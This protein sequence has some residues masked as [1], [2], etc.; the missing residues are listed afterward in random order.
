MG[1]LKR[2]GNKKN[3]RLGLTALTLGMASMTLHAETVFGFPAQPLNL[4]LAQLARE[5]GVN[6]LAQDAILA[7]Y[8]APALSGS[9]SVGDALAQLLRGT[10][11]HYEQQDAKTFVIKTAPVAPSKTSSGTANM[12]PTI[13]VSDVSESRTQGFLADATSTATRTDTPIGQTAQS[14]QVVTKDLIKSK[15]AQSALDVLTTVSGVTVSNE[16]VGRARVFVRGL[17]APTM[18]NGVNDVGPISSLQ[19]PVAGIER[20]EVLKGADSILSGAMSPG[21]VV[22]VALK[23]PTANT[24]REV[25]VQT[26]SY[27]NFLTSLD[28]GGAIDL[29]KQFLYRLVLSADRSSRTSDGYDG[30]KNVYLA[31]SLTWKSDGRELTAGYQH[32][33]QNV[34][35]AA[36]TIA[37]ANG[38]LT[39]TS[40]PTPSQNSVIQTDT[41]FVNFKQRLGDHIE[42]ENRTQ[43]QTSTLD[44]R[45]LY[46]LLGGTPQRAVYQSINNLST[47][48]GVDTDTHIKAKFATGELSHTLLAGYDYNVYWSEQ[49]GQPL[50]QVA[51]TFPA[52]TLPPNTS[53]ERIYPSDRSYFE[54]FYLQDQIAWGGLHVLASVARGKSWSPDEPSQS[55][56]TPNLG[57]LYQVTD[58]IA[59]YTNL[60]RSYR[61]SSQRLDDGTIAPPTSGQSAEAGFK[62]NLLDERLSI[63]TAVFRNTVDNSVIVDPV[64]GGARLGNA[65]T[66]RGAELN[67]TGNLSPGLNISGGYAYTT[68]VKDEG[69]NPEI[70]PRHSANLW[71]TYDLQSE[72]WR[73]WGAGVGVDA[74]SKYAYAVPQYKVFNPVPGQAQTDLTVYYRASTWSVNLGVKNV[75][76]R[77][78]YQNWA[79]SRVALNPGRLV[80]LTGSFNF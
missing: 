14:I 47:Y 34:P 32:Q 75:F 80:Y 23:L 46:A 19:T 11:L 51:G 69:G 45:N 30:G 24:V 4:T 61:P 36:A 40:R 5:A 42:I 6:I 72:R 67:I 27:N 16:G 9:L 62:F 44:R 64:T 41:V 28:L 35:P 33:Y 43:Y 56:W 22:N 13:T 12:L 49:R 57:V 70:V 65:Y 52:P 3:I 37:T 54:T 10:G 18:T 48:S 20:I 71:V 78:L 79:T 73:G 66:S 77:T 7:G 50:R 59:V 21:G 60:L 74:R 15:Q 38:P 17:S 1:I 76:D 53:P 63:T 29:D 2:W 55:K 8:R 26:G 25:M 68:V 58:S 31:P 39:P